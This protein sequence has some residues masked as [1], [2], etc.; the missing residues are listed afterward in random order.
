MLDEPMPPVYIY[1]VKTIRVIFVDKLIPLF[2][3]AALLLHFILRVLRHQHC[4][5]LLQQL[6]WLPISEEIKYKSAFMCYSSITGSTPSY[7]SEL[8]QLYSP[9]TLSALH[10]THACSYSDVSHGLYSFSCFGPPMWNNL[11]NQR[12]QILY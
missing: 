5:P 8:L 1:S 3:M 12:S 7:L 4:T 9:S 6:H 2:N 10:Q 11:S